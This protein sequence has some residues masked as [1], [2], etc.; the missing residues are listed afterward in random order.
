MT[1]QE[2]K[3]LIA[4]FA[5][6]QEKADRQFN[7][8]LEKSR[9]DFDKRMEK[10]DAKLN[11][12]SEEVGGISNNQG[13]HAEQYFQDILLEKLTFGG[14]KYDRMIHNLECFDKNKV[15][16]IEFDIV[17]VNGKSVAIIETKNRIHPSFVKEFVEKRLPKFK[18][19]LP[20]FSKCKTYLGIAGFSFSKKVL[21]E[22]R[23]Y[24]IGVIRQIGDSVE[25]ETSNLK[26]Y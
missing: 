15:P 13:H 8:R 5:I 17:L 12:I 6:T 24:G 25:M 1:D 2:L 26:A 14:Q 16:Q 21:E 23:K 18:E 9:A 22:A 10:L 7:Q 19:F 20:E 11:K 4:S 3:D